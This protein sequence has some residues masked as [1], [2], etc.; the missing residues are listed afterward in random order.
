[1]AQVNLRDAI[2]VSV[3]EALTKVGLPHTPA[4]QIGVLNG[5]HKDA[6]KIDFADPHQIR[7]IIEDEIINLNDLV[8]RS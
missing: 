6:D 4:N 3:D 7:A 8:Y 5:M 1:M 2:M